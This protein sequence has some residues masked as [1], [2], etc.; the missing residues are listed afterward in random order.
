MIVLRTVSSTWGEGTP[1]KMEYGYMGPSWPSFHALLAVYKTLISAFFCSQ[2]PIFTPKWQISR[3]FKFQGLKISRVQFHDLKLVKNSVH[4]S[5]FCLY[6]F[7]S[8][9]SQIWQWLVHKAPLF[10]P[11]DRTLTPQGKARPPA[12]TYTQQEGWMFTE[13]C[14]SDQKNTWATFTAGINLRCQLS[15]Q[16]S[17][18]I[19]TN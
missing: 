6:K 2:Y 15:T 18:L 1:P 5:T 8:L 14:Y 12:S 16:F 19:Y 7:S 9:G 4:K 11:L 3:N 17:Y 10:G 13:Q